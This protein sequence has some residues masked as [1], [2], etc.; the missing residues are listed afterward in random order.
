MKVVGEKPTSI[1][2]LK[3]LYTFGVG[4]FLGSAST[5]SARSEMIDADQIL[6][7]RIIR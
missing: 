7:I 3:T 5:S 1:V 4:A 6:S 2:E